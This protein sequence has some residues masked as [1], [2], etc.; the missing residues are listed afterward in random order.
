L[1]QG[2]SDRSEEGQASVRK[3]AVKYAYSLRTWSTILQC[4]FWLFII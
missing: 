4:F 1:D 2:Q 3:P